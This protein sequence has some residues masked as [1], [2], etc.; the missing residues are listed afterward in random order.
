MAGYDINNLTL[1]DNSFEVLPDGDY[2]FTVASHEV[3]YA[4]SQKMPANTQQITC[5]LDIPVMQ[6]GEVKI[7]TVTNRL[8]VYSKALFAI[9]QFAEAIGLAPEKGRVSLDLNR[10]DGMTGM[11]AI[12]TRESTKG[13]AFNSVKMFYAPSKAP[14]K[15]DN[16]EAWAKRNDFMPAGDLDDIFDN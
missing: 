11:C 1:D 9:R 4:T 16:E 13:N 2:R 8:N 3:G 10:M 5:K 14:V 6:D 12:E 7:V 15:A